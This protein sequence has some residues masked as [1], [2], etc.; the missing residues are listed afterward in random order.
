MGSISGSGIGSAAP[1]G[2]WARSTMARLAAG[3]LAMSLL[4]GA[5]P[6]GTLDLQF[7]EL[8]SAKGVLRICVTTDPAH[9]PD[10]KGE[11]RAITR[12]IGASQPHVVIEGLPG[13]DYAVSVIHDENGNGKLDTFAGIPREGIGFSR[14]P[15]L[16]FG[17]PRFTAASFAVAGAAVKQSVRMKYFL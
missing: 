3:L 13:G 9:F 4:P 10:C 14:N 12:T 2:G 8:R 7:T 17:P 5:A 1:T 15:K 6:T 16:A 11:A